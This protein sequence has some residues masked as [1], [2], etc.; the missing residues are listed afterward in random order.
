MTALQPEVAALSALEELRTHLP[1]TDPDRHD[2]DRVDAAYGQMTIT[3]PDPEVVTAQRREALVRAM[4][5][6]GGRW[7][8]GRGVRLY[9]SLGYGRVG[10][11]RVAQDFRYW[12]LA[13]RLKRHDRKGVT[14]YTFREIGGGR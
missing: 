5:A 4:E 11:S 1:L 10:K 12:H 9:A 14:Y 2:L 7:K 8:T 3:T 6:E 13:G